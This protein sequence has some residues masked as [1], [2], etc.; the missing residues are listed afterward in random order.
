MATKDNEENERGTKDDW[1]TLK[2]ILDQS[3]SLK[4]RVFYKIRELRNAMNKRKNDGIKIS[5]KDSIEFRLD[6]KKKK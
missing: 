4:Q 1:E 5:K 6:T 3:P 2:V